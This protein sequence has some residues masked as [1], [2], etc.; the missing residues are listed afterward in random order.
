[1]INSFRV[2]IRVLVLSQFAL[3]LAVAGAQEKGALAESSALPGFVAILPQLRQGG[4]VIYFRHGPTDASRGA[5][6]EKAD[7][8]RCETQRNLSAAGRALMAAVGKAIRALAVPVGPVLSSPYCRCKDTATLALGHYTVSNDLHFALGVAPAERARLAES[9]RAMLA[10]P[11]PRGK[12]TFIVSHTANL[13][14][15]AGIWPKPEGAAYVF[16]P[17]GNGRFEAL[18]A[19][20]PEEWAKAAGAPPARPR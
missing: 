4:L 6:D 13:K 2:A 10:M 9:L 11:P 3:W 20:M 1:M 7:L 19:V 16:R 5:T 15:A 14:E 17:L 12:N 8:A 18:A